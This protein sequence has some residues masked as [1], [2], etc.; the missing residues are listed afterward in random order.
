M[1]IGETSLTMDKF[2]FLTVVRNGRRIATA[3]GCTS[4]I[5][6]GPGFL[7]SPGA[8]LPTIMDA[9]SFMA[10]TGGGGRDRSTPVTIQSGPRH[11]CPSSD[12][13]GEDGVST[14]VLVSAAASGA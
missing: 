10:A 7:M 9:G 8:G 14:L 2:G 3:A 11:M 13:A 6:D 1:A 12:L 4:P 5:M